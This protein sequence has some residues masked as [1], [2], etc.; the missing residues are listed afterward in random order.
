LGT[1]KR[2]GCGGTHRLLPGKTLRLA[3]LLK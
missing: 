3:I 2:K 1:P